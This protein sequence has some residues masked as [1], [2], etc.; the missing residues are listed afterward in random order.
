MNIAISAIRYKSS[1]LNRYELITSLQALGHSVF[2]IGLDS[3]DHLHPDYEKY[4]VTYLT[5]SLGRTNT[6]PFKEIIT[7]RNAM[8][9]FRQNKIDCLI[10]YGI[11]TFPTMVTAAKLAGVKRVLCIVNGSGRLFQ[12]RG[13]KGFLV[14]ALSYRLIC[15]AFVLADNILFQNRD[16]LQL[17]RQK[18]HLL[19]KNYDLVNG[20]GVNL[21]DYPQ[22]PLPAE[23]V[24]LMIGRLTGDKGVNEYIRA[25]MTVKK[26]YSEAQFYLVGPHDDDDRTIDQELFNAALLEGIVTFTGKTEDVRPYIAK[27]RVFV[28]PSYHEGTPRTVLEAMSMGRP[29]I[30]THAT[31]CRETVEDTVNGFKVPVGN[32][33]MLTK[34]ML[35]MIEHPSEIELMAQKSRQLCEQK[36][37]VYEVNK[38]I[39]AKLLF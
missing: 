15:L 34:K 27:C 1:K 17:I 6:N 28:L 12:L 5:V 31:G 18:V 30:T 21:V 29:V 19:K 2:Y 25:A 4:N 14:K 26:K 3:D 39:I 37:N 35:W 38:K 8:R 24:F 33:D 32:I 10:V 7:F 36:Y 20:S 9:V 23:P 16:D 22:K 11:R 13:I